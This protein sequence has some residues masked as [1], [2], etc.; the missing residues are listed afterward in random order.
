[1]VRVVRV[2]RMVKVERE[3]GVEQIDDHSKFQS[4]V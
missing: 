4:D 3:V 1:M 2:G